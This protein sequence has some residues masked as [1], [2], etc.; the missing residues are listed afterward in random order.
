MSRPSRRR[1][2]VAVCAAVTFVLAVPDS[3]GAAAR[4]DVKPGAV[5]GVPATAGPGD[6]VSVRWSVT[7]AGRKVRSVRVSFLLS[8]DGKRSSDDRRLAAVGKLRG[9]ARKRRAKGQ[10][11]V[12]IPATTAAG[13]YRILVCVDRLKG[14]REGKRARRN[15]CRASK[16]LTIV[17]SAPPAPGPFG[18]A[19]G[20]PANPAPAPP[21]PPEPGAPQPPDDGPAQP[22]DVQPTLDTERAA[23][24][25]IG[26][27]GGTLEATAA[28]GTAFRLSV[29]EG[30]LFSTEQVTM[31]PVAGV[32]GMPLSGGLAGAVDLQPDGLA[33]QEAATLTITPP[34]PVP[35]EEQT[36][37]SWHGGGEDFHLHP[38]LPG[39]PVVLPLA[40]FSAAGLARATQAERDAQLAR[41]PE[42]SEDVLAQ[43]LGYQTQLERSGRGGQLEPTVGSLRRHYERRVRPAL[44]QA[45][46][47]LP[48][49]VIERALVLVS[50]WSLMTG[51][52]GRTRE[53]LAAELAEARDFAREALRQALSVADSRCRE[54]DPD[55][56]ERLP[57]LFNLGALI[58]AWS[59]S[60]AAVRDTV[61]RC[62]RF[63]LDFTTK[64]KAVG[65]DGENHNNG[66]EGKGGE[67]FVSIPSVPLTLEYPEL[68]LAGGKAF[69]YAQP[70]TWDRYPRGN[71]VAFNG[72]AYG[73]VFDV[74][75]LQLPLNLVRGQG[76]PDMRMRFTPGSS[77]DHYTLGCGLVDSGPFSRWIYFATFSNLH[78]LERRVG[79]NWPIQ[80]L[81]GQGHSP[82]PDPHHFEVRN[83][84]RP[85]ASAYADKSYER[86][87]NYDQGGHNNVYTLTEQTLFELRHT[88]GGAR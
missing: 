84:S 40:H 28:D 46:T 66:R 77:V 78:M 22:V 26:P 19:P 21:P 11:R 79:S 27:E 2:A 68:T 80:S 72:T 9:L 24:G 7:R 3:S 76:R 71:C 33:L 65:P 54:G 85:G 35:L 34:E 64:L 5:A 20:A 13:T 81:T 12:A 8:R 70:R 55:V 15:N 87:R 39:E 10:R 23:V 48:L 25:D 16:A 69:S 29:P 51:V 83:W 4:L 31:T 73:H 17:V 32:A 49:S 47:A 61:E 44:V 36:G 18:P 30:A 53:R 14:A 74:T 41:L 42:R 63:E 45:R 67:V 57:W 58:G 50:D 1:S 60:D 59:I 82:P 38:L 75:S 37:V 6:S 43:E 62:L 52:D 88:P 56:V 86:S